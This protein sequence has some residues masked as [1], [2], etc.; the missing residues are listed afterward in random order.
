MGLLRQAPPLEELL[1]F[2]DTHTNQEGS[3]YYQV[4]D[5]TFTRWLQDYNILHKLREKKQAPPKEELEQFLLVHTLKQ[6][7]E[8]YDVKT[9]T[10]RRWLEELDLDHLHFDQKEMISLSRAAK[11]LG[12]SRAILSQWFRKG[13]IPGA[14][15]VN[16][17]RVKLTREAIRY[18][19]TS[20]FYH[21]LLGRH[22]KLERRRILPM[23]QA[24]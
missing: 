11:E 24:G 23:S 21:S 22:Q 13:K 10:L 2:L 8:H 3:I 4:S 16:A 14:K 20:P 1:I 5:K 9:P 15:K 17:T 12:L 6:A 18:L 19:R 7:E